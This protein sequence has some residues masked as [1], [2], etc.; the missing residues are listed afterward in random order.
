MYHVERKILKLSQ[1]SFKTLPLN[2]KIRSANESNDAQQKFNEDTLF[3]MTKSRTQF[4]CYSFFRNFHFSYFTKLK[5]FG[6]FLAFLQH[7]YKFCMT[8]NIA[9][10]SGHLQKGDIFGVM[11]CTRAHKETKWP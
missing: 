11:L 5:P 3:S 2:K 9:K 8:V 7:K 10:L 4:I 6:I 1:V